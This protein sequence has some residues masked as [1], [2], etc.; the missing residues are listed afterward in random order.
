MNEMYQTGQPVP[1]KVSG[2]MPAN[3]GFISKVG[4]RYSEN[5]FGCRWYAHV[6]EENRFPVLAVSDNEVGTFCPQCDAKLSP[7]EKLDLAGGLVAILLDISSQ[8]Y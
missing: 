6:C 7:I 3:Q 8:I 1:G 2:E 4:W 5:D